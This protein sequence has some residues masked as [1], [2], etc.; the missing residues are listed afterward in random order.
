MNK[1]ARDGGKPYKTKKFP[2]WPY[3]GKR[4]VELI[5][6]VTESGKWWRMSGDKVNE[7]EKQFADFINVKHCLGVTNGTNA[8]ELSLY[9]LGIGP[10]DEVIIPAFTFISTATAVIYANATPVLVD[11]YPD[12]FCMLPEAFEKAI[13]SKTKVVIPVHM[14]GQMCEMDKI[15][16]IAKKNNIKIIE[17]AAH[18][19]GAKWQNINAGSFGDMAI[20][21][22]QNGKLMTCGEG[23]A[24]V[25]NDQNL[26]ERSFLAHGVGRPKDDRIYEHTILGSNYRMNEFQAAILIAQLEKLATFNQR[27]EENTKY[28]DDLMKNINGITPQKYNENLTV[29]PHYMYMFYYDSKYFGGLSR[30]EF[31]DCLIAEGI[32]AFIAYPVIS[33]TSFFKANNFAG[34]IKGYNKAEEADLTNARNIARNAVWL[35]HFTLLGDYEDLNE[36]AGAVNKIQKNFK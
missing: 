30:L 36:I 19:H 11:V 21:S 22:F 4:E 16:E 33:E 26:Y 24:I 20:F 15:C 8:I 10:G 34:R 23:G 5:T 35:P 31:V 18:A 12:T 7:F 32:P 3:S 27:R 29:N 25:T 9:A 13:T 17:D 14:A 6:E 28:L 2:N 1:L